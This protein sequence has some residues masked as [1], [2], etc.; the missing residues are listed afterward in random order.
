MNHQRGQQVDPDQVTTVKMGIN[1][2][3]ANWNPPAIKASLTN[4]VTYA[5]ILAAQGSLLHHYILIREVKKGNPITYDMIADERYLY[6]IYNDNKPMQ[7]VFSQAT[8][9]VDIVINQNW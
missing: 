7:G 4:M 8:E 9:G 3:L 2:A 5:S 1:T 6:A